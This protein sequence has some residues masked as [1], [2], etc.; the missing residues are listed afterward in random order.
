M[1]HYDRLPFAYEASATDAKPREGCVRDNVYVFDFC[2]NTAG[3]SKLK[4]NGK[5]G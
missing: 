3:V 2:V 4:I 5:M 1:K